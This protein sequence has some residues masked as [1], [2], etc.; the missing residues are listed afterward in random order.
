ME[1]LI[2]RVLVDIEDNAIS[3]IVPS[4]PFR[5]LLEHAMERCNGCKALLLSMDEA[6]SRNFPLGHE[7]QVQLAIILPMD[8][9]NGW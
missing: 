2:E 5:S 3:A 7:G 8:R 1:P 9:S 4:A 6:W